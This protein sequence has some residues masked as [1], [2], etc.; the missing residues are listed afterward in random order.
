ME[1]NKLL[2]YT[3]LRDK[4]LTEGKNYFQNPRFRK[5]NF[6]LGI[7]E[8]KD[9]YET[10]VD[11]VYLLDMN[12]PQKA[13]PA[14]DLMVLYENYFRSRDVEKVIRMLVAAIEKQYPKETA[15]EREI[16]E[17][18]AVTIPVEGNEEIPM[19]Y[20]LGER[21]GKCSISE[22]P[23]KEDLLMPIAEKENANL[24]MISYGDETVLAVPVH[25]MEEYEENLQVLAELRQLELEQAKELENQVF[26]RNRNMLLKDPE[27]IK[28]LLIK[29]KVQKRSLFAK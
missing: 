24:Q 21:Y 13:S 7:R 6:E 4:I 1:E 26:D 25:S 5:A 3:E 27:E 29:G 10:S 18:Q 15:V 20:L 12:Q 22:L 11:M 28:E 8:E 16:S 19:V 23:D 9:N 17:C 14:Y 2:S